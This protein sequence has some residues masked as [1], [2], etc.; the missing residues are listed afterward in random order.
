M[1]EQSAPLKPSVRVSGGTPNGFPDFVPLNPWGRPMPKPAQPP[2]PPVSQVV[3]R[4]LRDGGKELRVGPKWPA[5]CAAML[6]QAI[7]REIAAGREKRW[8]D[9]VVVTF[10]AEIGRL[11]TSLTF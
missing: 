11:P 2:R 9:P 6:C 7:E 8:A 1:S 5:E 4:D 3:V 10:T